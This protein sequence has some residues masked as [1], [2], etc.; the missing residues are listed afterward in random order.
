M[1]NTFNEKRE[2]LRSHRTGAAFAL[3]QF[4][5][6]I[7]QVASH[8][9]EC[10]GFAD[11]GRRKWT[12]VR[13]Q[14]TFLDY[15]RRQGDVYCLNQPKEHANAESPGEN[16]HESTGHAVET[17]Q[18]GVTQAVAQQFSQLVDQEND[19]K[20]DD[21]KAEVRQK[22]VVFASVGLQ[23]GQA[24][25]EQFEAHY[26]GDDKGQNGD[27]LQQQPFPVALISTPKQK[28]ANEQIQDGKIC[29][30]Y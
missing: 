4:F 11:D 21:G 13:I 1:L 28:Q 18:Q 27:D 6:G 16:A 8:G 10:I 7:E 22:A 23:E 9:K 19:G 17:T 12:D 20:E 5:E 24:H 26:H 3:Q 29:D 2:L 14:V 30:E 15:L 25:V